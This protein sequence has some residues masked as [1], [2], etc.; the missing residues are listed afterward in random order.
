[1]DVLEPTN[2]L[3]EMLLTYNPKLSVS[4]GLDHLAQRLEPIISAKFEDDL[5]GHPWTVI[6]SHLDQVAGK[7]PKTYSTSDLQTQLKMLTRRLGNFGFP[8]DDNR[9]T[10][11]TLGRELTIVRNARAH[12]DP[13]S[14]LDAW[15]AHDYCVRL[16]E[17]F[18]DAAGLVKANELRQEALLVYVNEQGIAPLPAAAGPEP[19][20]PGTEADLETAPP[21]T[22][23]ELVAP[24]AEVFAREPSEETMVVGNSRLPF[25]PWAPVP[26]GDVSVLDALPK[27]AAKQKVRAVATEIVEAEG[28][29]HLERLA[30][31]TAASFGVQ[32]LR[33]QRAKK[34]IYQVKAAGL[35]VDSDKFVWPDGIDPKTWAEFRPNSSLVS[36]NFLHISPVEIANAMRFLKER[37]PSSAEY[38]IDASTLRTFGRKRRMKQVVAHLGKARALV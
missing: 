34:I 22:E 8:F 13:F 4:E 5:A 1:M 7:P 20:P 12:G 11:S 16:L 19:E 2:H 10:V 21:E 31:L 26:V 27:A 25:E 30:Q 35:N 36:R 3:E 15:R 18:G 23:A 14:H 6:L 38:E 32:R 37:H 9:Q 29:I 24:D 33:N 28:P 17:Q